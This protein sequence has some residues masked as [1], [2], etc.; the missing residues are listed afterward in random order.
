M[1]RIFFLNLILC[2]MTGLIPLTAAAQGAETLTP[3][4]DVLAPS[5]TNLTAP[6]TPVTPVPENERSVAPAA[7]VITAPQQLGLPNPKKSD[8]FDPSALDP[9]EIPEIVLQE[10]YAVE[11]SCENNYFYSSFHDCRCVAVKFMDA[12]LKS[13]PS[14]SKDQVLSSIANQ[15]ADEVRVAGFV[16]HGCEGFMKFNRPNDFESF[17]TCSA[18]TVAREYARNPMLNMRY[19]ENLRKNAY[20]QCGIS[21]NINQLPQSPYDQ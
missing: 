12:R 7:P 10:A 4:N 11:K 20:V 8:D 19:I 15:C 14:R 3:R 9:S 17:C 16:Y 1:I 6:S 21:T 13:D 18:N 5:R 2:A